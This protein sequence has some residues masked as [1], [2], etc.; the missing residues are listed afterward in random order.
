VFAAVDH[1]GADITTHQGDTVSSHTVDGGGY[2]VHKP[3]T[4]GWNGYGDQQH[5][6][7][8]AVRMNVR[9]VADRLT[10]LVDQTGANVV[11]VCG[12][13]RSRTDVVSALPGRVKDRV[14]QLHAGARGHRVREDETR[15]VVDE[16]FER[17]SQTT[18]GDIASRFEAEI[19]RHSGLA[20]EGLEAV[21][22][23]LREGAVETLIVAEL[24]DAT[25]VTG[26]GR[27][28]IAPD[29]D[30]LSDLSS[31]RL[32]AGWRGPTRRCRSRLSALVRRWFG[33]TTGSIPPTGSG[34]GLIAVRTQGR[35]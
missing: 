5:S 29:A 1:L 4:A 23:E 18:A 12:G 9:A 22:A 33:W 14:T 3:A 11:F 35:D 31:A 26:E 21:C 8:E 34:T 6:A 24:A 30:A 16:E 32:R 27:T 28:T 19:K 10:E 25:V 2:P 17:R 13:V 7:E 15:D 20:V